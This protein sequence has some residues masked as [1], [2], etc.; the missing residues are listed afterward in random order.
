MSK[1]M[2]SVLEVVMLMGKRIYVRSVKVESTN[3]GLA[4][5]S[6]AGETAMPVVKTNFYIVQE[7]EGLN[8]PCVRRFLD[9]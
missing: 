8:S 6:V 2:L 1:F 3:I 5:K 9:V 7:V 4:W